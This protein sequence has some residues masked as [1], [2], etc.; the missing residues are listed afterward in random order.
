MDNRQKILDQ[1]LRLF[2]DRGYDA[3]GVQEIAEAA[4]VTKPTLY[5]YFGSKHGLL[6][7][8]LAEYFQRLNQALAAA[9]DYQH[10]LPLSL[11]RVI[12]AY[13]DFARRYPTF[14]RLQLALWFS[15]RYSQAQAA[16]A[17]WSSQ[18]FAMIEE[19]FA[20]AVSDHGNMAGR[21]RAYASSLIGVVNTYI[22]LALNGYTELD[23]HLVQQAVRQFQYGIYS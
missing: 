23:D 11:E 6:E 5:H 1:A 22:G 16:V 10:D 3:V 4:G 13:F 12:R 2:A 8:L 19:M 9:A 14:Y 17:R 20:R 21:Q 15:P 7:S 18:Q